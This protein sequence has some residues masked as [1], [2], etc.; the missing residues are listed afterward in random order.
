MYTIQKKYRF[1][2]KKPVFGGFLRKFEEIG[3]KTQSC[4]ILIFVPENDKKGIKINLFIC[5]G[6][7]LK[8]IT[9]LSLPINLF[10][11]FFLTG[12]ETRIFMRK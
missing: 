7:F 9:Y 4:D 8:E 11:L 6:R 3:G 5:F 1:W 2:T 10:L 12:K